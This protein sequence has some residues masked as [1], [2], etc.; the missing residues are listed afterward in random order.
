MGG[1][2]MKENGWKFP[3]T[4]VG[5]LSLPRMLIGTNWILGYSH[6]GQASD[7]LIHSRNKNVNSIAAILD[8]YLDYGVDAIMGP[9]ST[10]GDYFVEAI[11]LTEEKRGVDIIMIDT[12]VLNVNDSADAREEARALIKKSARM[13][14][15]LCLPHHS[16]VEQLVNKNK[17]QIVRISDY[18]TM[19]RDE[20]MIPGFSAHMPEVILYS[21]MNGYDAETY[22]SIFNCM[23]FLMQIEIETVSRIIHEAKKPVMTIKPMAAGRVTP[24]VGLTFSYCA[25]RPIDMVTVGAFT[26]DEVTEDIEIA[27]AALENR[28]PNL[29]KRSSPATSQ[30]L[31]K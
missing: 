23:G 6:R 31:L 9:C 5:G 1:I 10:A 24:Y 14:C 18:L 16:S 3:R 28:F 13:G 15:K 11:K 30:S 29:E 2:G 19:I 27:R 4:T 7:T 25:L 8:A 26:P 20:G 21:D 17:E 12:P 22:I